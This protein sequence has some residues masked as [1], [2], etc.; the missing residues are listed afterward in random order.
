MNIQDIYR[1]ALKYEPLWVQSNLKGYHE[2]RVKCENLEEFNK[3]IHNHRKLFIFELVIDIDCH[4]R[5]ISNEISEFA[6]QALIKDN[7]THQVW[8]SSRSPHIHAFFKDMHTYPE[9][10]RKIIKLLM[11]KRYTLQYF[12]SGFIDKG[13]INEKRTIRDFNGQHEVTGKY[14][15]LIYEFQG[16]LSS[17]SPL[18]ES[19]E[20]FFCS[21]GSS[22]ELYNPIPLHIMDKL[23]EY[24]NAQ[25]NV[26]EIAYIKPTEANL[27]E[28]QD[29]ITYCTENTLRDDGKKTILSRNIAIASLLLGYDSNARHR[30]YYK[31]SQN[32][33]SKI[34]KNLIGWDKHFQKK[35]NLRVNW[36]E[37]N[38]WYMQRDNLHGYSVESQIIHANK[39]I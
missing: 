31:V 1:E 37:I 9:E 20:T 29:F 11:L 17:L 26:P 19:P 28:M 25:A 34:L 10:I 12:D 5:D 8:D 4:N 3:T 22:L 30:I 33:T 6:S 7:I 13:M 15:T 23:R 39:P 16:K 36:W 24:C 18:V 21:K 2:P 14:K 38:R 27:R 32:S 35:P